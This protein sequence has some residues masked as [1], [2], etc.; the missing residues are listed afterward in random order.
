M[1]PFLSQLR[2]G[3]R[4]LKPYQPGRPLE[5]VRAEFGLDRVVKLAS[6]EYPEGPFPEVL[7]VLR[8]ELAHLHRYPDGGAVALHEAAAQRYGLTPGEFCFGNGADELVRLLVQALCSPG[9]EVVHAHP[10]FP[11]YAIGARG[12]FSVG[13][14][15]P[16]RADGVHDLDA[17]L[18]AIGERTRL[19]FVCNPNNPTGTWVDQD[20]LVSFLERVPASTVVVLDEAYVEFADD[21]AFPDFLALRE[22][23]PNLASLRSFS[24]IYSLAALRVGY[25]IGHPEL[26]DVLRRTRPPFNVNRL[27]QRAA[28]TALAHADRVAGR[29]ATNRRRRDELEAGLRELGCSTL[30]SQTNFLYTTP[31][32][33][34]GD[35]AA[36]LLRE[37]VIV[38]PLAGFG[39]R[40]GSFRVNVGLDEENEFFLAA[41]A[42]VL[43]AAEGN[44]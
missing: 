22:R 23:F 44:A 2:E 19:V 28:A 6:N 21:P 25:C 5:E 36:A 14:A 1:Q 13:H 39:V 41:L 20:A 33:G 4:Q 24:K 38:R 11:S 16:L 15:V 9:D 17:M 40:D 42:R 27:A 3:V 7:E 30:P 12:H 37:G 18:G 10:S 43:R 26:I 8:E 29:R 31:P 35:V 34:R 32:A